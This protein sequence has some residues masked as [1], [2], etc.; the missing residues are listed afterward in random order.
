MSAE[1]VGYYEH[2]RKDVLPF[3]PLN[4]KRV[5]DVGCGVGATSAW[6]RSLYPG[7]VFVGVEGNPALLGGLKKA[8]NEAHIADLNGLIP[9][10]GKPDVILLLDVLEH[11]N[12]P[13]GVL[14]HMRGI[15]APG[16]TIIISLPNVAH[17]SVLWS[18]LRG[19]FDYTEAGIM[20]RTHLHFYYKGSILSLVESA[21]LTPRKIHAIGISPKRKVVNDVTL[22]LFENRIAKQYMV[23]AQ[24]A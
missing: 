9:D 19:R 15:L 5:L 7:T 1:Q 21:G 18:L 10:V 3:M 20:D 8:V 17:Y 23:S 13:V 14:T 11:L 12:D 22:R 4:P 6:L 16:G 2:I 24:S